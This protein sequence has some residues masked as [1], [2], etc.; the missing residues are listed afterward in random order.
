MS[1]CATSSSCSLRFTVDRQRSLIASQISI[2]KPRFLLISSGNRYSVSPIISHPSERQMSLPSCTGNLQLISLAYDID[3]DPTIKSDNRPPDFCIIY[4]RK[5]SV[6]LRGR[7]ADSTDTAFSPSAPSAAVAGRCRS[8]CSSVTHARGVG[9]GGRRDRKLPLAPPPP[10]S[11]VANASHP[12]SPGANGRHSPSFPHTSCA[13]FL[14]RHADLF[15][16]SPLHLLPSYPHKPHDGGNRSF[17]AVG[18]SLG[19]P[20]H[21]CALIWRGSRKRCSPTMTSTSAFCRWRR[22]NNATTGGAAQRAGKV[23]GD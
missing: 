21:C 20:S 7:S 4:R 9:L 1:C 18:G 10:R 15:F 8:A 23:S 14:P 17:P 22:L 12:H 6:A 5:P 13:S 11:A 3:V 2:N 19:T 16:P